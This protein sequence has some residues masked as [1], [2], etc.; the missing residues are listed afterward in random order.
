MP[1]PMDRRVIIN[2]QAQNTT[3]E[4]YTCSFTRKQL[5][6]LRSLAREKSHQHN[7]TVSVQ[8]LIRQAI[9]RTYGGKYTP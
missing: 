8:D 9:N 6:S 4:R 3:T 2:R 7:T 5:D 1:R